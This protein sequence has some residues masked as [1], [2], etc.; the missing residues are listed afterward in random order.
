[1]QTNQSYSEQ[2]MKELQTTPAQKQKK[3]TF[4]F[5][6]I[7]ALVVLLAVSAYLLLTNLKPDLNANLNNLNRKV[8]TLLNVS[9]SQHSN[10]DSSSLR[11]ANTNLQ[12]SLTGYKRDVQK[13]LEADRKA[14]TENLELKEL[15]TRLNDAKLNSLLDRSFS[16]EVIYLIDQILNLTDEIYLASDSEALTTVLKK[17]YNDLKLIRAQFEEV[18]L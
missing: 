14:P 5:I 7:G 8:T 16:T 18:K 1:M 13:Y 3:E 4:W 9:S 2:F 10:L 6:L 15:E 11:S 17:N 12:L